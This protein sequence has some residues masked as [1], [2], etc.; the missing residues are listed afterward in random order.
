MYSGSIN[1]KDKELYGHPTIKPKEL[2]E[3]FV[4]NHSRQGDLVFDPFAGTGTTGVVCGYTKRKF[5]GIEKD[6]KWFGVAK[7]RIENNN[8][9]SLEDLF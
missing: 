4:I 9:Q 5:V 3:K 1:R 7:N 8:Q 2:V 6:K